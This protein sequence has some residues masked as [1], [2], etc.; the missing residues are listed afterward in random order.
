M[1]SDESNSNP[2]KNEFLQK[3]PKK[4]IKFQNEF[5]KSKRI[6]TLNKS[7]IDDLISP[8]NQPKN[9]NNDNIND[10]NFNGISGGNNSTGNE[11]E[12]LTKD[13]DCLSVDD[14]LQNKNKINDI[15]KRKNKRI[16]IKNMSNKI[17]K[18]KNI[19]IG[20][21]R[22]NYETINNPMM[23][24]SKNFYHKRIK[25]DKNKKE[26]DEKEEKI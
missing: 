24:T 15:N 17:Q 2:K 26:E 25:Y 20:I 23:S 5:L 13:L 8:Q 16:D 21:D 19:N 9:E 4:E 10:I 18:E 1:G 7:I 11:I 22:K 12:K 3:K 6:N 14:R